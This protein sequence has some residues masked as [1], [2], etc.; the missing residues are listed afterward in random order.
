VIFRNT[1]AARNHWLAVQLRGRR[2]NRDGIGAMI[3]VIGASGLQQWN[4]VT[5]ATGYASASD[6]TAFFGMGQDAQA[7]SVVIKWPSGS[8]QTL[9]DVKCDRYLKV[10]E[11]ER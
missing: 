11:P 6:R 9:T 3:H 4:R 2:S 8:V 5:T 1:S 10:E 7:R